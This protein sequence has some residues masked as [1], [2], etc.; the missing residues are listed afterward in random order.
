MQIRKP[1]LVRLVDYDRAEERA[2]RNLNRDEVVRLER[3]ERLAAVRGG[4]CQPMH[5]VV[6]RIDRYRGGPEEG[7]W[8]YDW[9]SIEE[10]R[11]TWG[12]RSLLKAVRELREDYE[13]TGPDRFSVVGGE[14]YALYVTPREEQIETLADTERPTYG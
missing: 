3:S 12:F 13:R 11:R 7:G 10:V 6:V 8:Y 14:D 1:A 5:V 9:H 2:D 4:R